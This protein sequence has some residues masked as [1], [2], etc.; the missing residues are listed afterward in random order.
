MYSILNTLKVEKSSQ[1]TAFFLLIFSHTIAP[2]ARLHALVNSTDS[3][4]YKD[5]DENAVLFAQDSFKK[6]NSLMLCEACP[7][8]P[9]DVL[10]DS[11]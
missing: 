10:P 1:M 11:L 8:S 7:L 5:L 4:A 6:T 2:T 9:S 3:G